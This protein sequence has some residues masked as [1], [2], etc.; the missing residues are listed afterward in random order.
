MSFLI[1]VRGMTIVLL[2]CSSH[3][4]KRVEHFIRISCSL[5]LDPDEVS[6]NID[7]KIIRP[8]NFLVL[9][10]ILTVT[11]QVTMLSEE[12]PLFPL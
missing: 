1:Q 9:R 7:M 11:L 4:E 8:V 6:L 3:R 10:S 5:S 2:Q 12:L